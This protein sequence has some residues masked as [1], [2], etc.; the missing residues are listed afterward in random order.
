MVTVVT[1]KKTRMCVDPQDLN[2]AITRERTEAVSLMSNA[3]YFSV[4]DVNQGFWQI[5]L[6]E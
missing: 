5:K 1:L 6:D 4:L 2:T 3:K